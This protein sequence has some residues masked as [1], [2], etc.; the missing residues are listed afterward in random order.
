M[1]TKLSSSAVWEDII[2]YSRAIRVGN[3]IEVAGTTAV[4][5]G[6]VIHT[7]DPYGQT[8][9]ILQVIEHAL[10]QLDATMEDVVRTRIFM[11]QI[12][13]WEDVGRAH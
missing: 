7:G 12:T 6:E 5:H 10:K 8:K 3:I 9:Y 11:T 1:K 13:D 2:G 4:K